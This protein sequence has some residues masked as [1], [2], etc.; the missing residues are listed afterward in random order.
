MK[1]CMPFSYMS[2]EVSKT[3]RRDVLRLG[4]ASCA[5]SLLAVLDGGCTPNDDGPAGSTRPVANSESTEN[6]KA[7]QTGVPMKIQYLEIVTP[8]VDALCSQYSAIHGITFNDP[9]A[10]LGGARTAKLKGGGLIGIRGPLR[11][12]ETPVIRPYVLVDDIKASVD[13]AADTGAEIAIPS[14]EIPGHGIIA[15]IIQGGIECGLWQMGSK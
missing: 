13:A 9:D 14:M 15:V 10:N 2:E 3:N 11:D 6:K 12:T 5:F 8:D 7:T 4:S 1:T